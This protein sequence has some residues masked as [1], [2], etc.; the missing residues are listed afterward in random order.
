MTRRTSLTAAPAKAVMDKKVLIAMSGGV[1]SSVAAFLTKQAGYDCIGVTMKLFQNEDIGVSRAKTCCSL[2]DV[3]DARSVARRLGIPYYVFN[4]SRDFKAQ[5]INR[6]IAAYESGATPNPCIDCNRYLKFDRLFQRA[7]ELGCEAIATGHYARIATQNGRYILKKALDR[8][9]DQSYV[10]YMLTQEQLAHIRFPLG[11]LGK[12]EVRGIA[13]AQ[14]FCNSEKPDSQD[15]CFIPD[16]DHTTFLRRHMDKTDLTG[17]ILDL[18]GQVIGKHPGAVRYTIG[19]RKG[20]GLALN[21]PVYICHKDMVAN[22]VTVGPEQSLYSRELWA[23]DMNWIAIDHLSAPMQVY[24]KI[25]YRQTEQSATAYPDE[26]GKIRLLFD[27]PQRAIT[28][29]QAVVLYDGDTVV[30]GGMIC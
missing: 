24:A 4:F 12:S 18:S 26:G 8:E 19:Q 7:R 29:G 16:G 22:T 25:R 27:K 21:Q 11:E 13:E 6:F 2:D 9:K 20:L 23:N 30:G 14:E 28:A 17:E 1:D 10:L 5:V 3:E 15:I